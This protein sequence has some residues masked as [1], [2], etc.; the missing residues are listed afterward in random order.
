MLGFGP[1]LFH[2]RVWPRPTSLLSFGPRFLRFKD[3]SRAVSLFT[4]GLVFFSFWDGLRFSWLDQASFIWKI[5]SSQHIFYFWAQVSWAWGIHLGPH[6][7]LLWTNVF[8]GSGL[9]WAHVFSWFIP[10]LFHWRDCL[11]SYIFSLWVQFKGQGLDK[12]VS[13]LALDLSFKVRIGLGTLFFF[14]GFDLVCD[15][16]FWGVGPVT[17]IFSFGG[18]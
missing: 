6:L 15:S 9:A 10:G 3:W 2:L 4:V 1:G 12:A 11:G 14:F 17:H 7:L 5:G 13:L 16:Y 8:S 18:G